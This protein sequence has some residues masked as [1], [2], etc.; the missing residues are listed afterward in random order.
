MVDGVVYFPFPPLQVNVSFFHIH[1]FFTKLF[2][3]QK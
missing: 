2:L 1:I 3:F